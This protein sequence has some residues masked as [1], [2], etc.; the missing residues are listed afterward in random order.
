MTDSQDP[1]QPTQ[2]ILDPRRVGQNGSGLPARELTDI[3]LLLHPVT[4]AA[5][6]IVANAAKTAP[7]HVL[8]RDLFESYAHISENVEEQETIIIGENGERVVNPTWTATDL[9]LRL[10]SID[11]LKSKALGFVFGRNV[12][13]SDIVFGQD[14]GRRISNKHFRVFLNENGIVML[15]DISTNGT[16]VDNVLLLSKANQVN[17]ARMLAHG[18]TITITHPDP[19][20]IVEFIVKVP[21]RGRLQAL[22]DDAQHEFLSNCGAAN[23]QGEAARPLVK[24]AY[25]ATMKWDGGDNYKILG[26]LAPLGED[27]HADLYR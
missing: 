9:A 23:G 21:S 8:F 15:Q 26:L 20:E 1:S 6:R 16:M 4:P 13:T 14:S 27:F 5:T 22:F 17:T 3:L 7:Q 2:R 19:A 12:A 24:R 25:R 18:S 10:S 11:T